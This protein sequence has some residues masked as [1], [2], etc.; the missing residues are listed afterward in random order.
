MKPPPE[1][2]DDLLNQWSDLPTP[3][4]RLATEVWR[5]VALADAESAQP[6]G[7]WAHVEE[8]FS[9]PS[10]A[11]MFVALCALS[12]LFLAEMR[13][14]N[15]QRERSAQLARSYLLLIDPLLNAPDLK[16]QP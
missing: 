9:R 3:P 10:F 4:P 8:W 16:N 12:G 5:K 14:H 13:V 15:L 6:A 11:V 1:P 2:L 7:W